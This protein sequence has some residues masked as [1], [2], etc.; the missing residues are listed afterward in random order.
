MALYDRYF[1]S[2]GCY[3]FGDRYMILLFPVSPPILLSCLMHSPK[4]LPRRLAALHHQ[5]GFQS[6]LP[7]HLNVLKAYGVNLRCDY[8]WRPLRN[9]DRTHQLVGIIP[10]LRHRHLPVLHS[11]SI[12]KANQWVFITLWLVGVHYFV[13]GV[14]ITNHEP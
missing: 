8:Q 3:A 5:R 9:C 14:I 1:A 13:A 6:P 2:Q 7:Q 12:L 10:Y 11:E 4:P